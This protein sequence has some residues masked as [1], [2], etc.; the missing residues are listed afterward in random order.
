MSALILDTETTGKNDPILLIEAAWL[1]VEDVRTLSITDTFSQRYKPSKP[2]E[3]GAMAVHHIFDEEL[4]GC[5]ASDTF[6]LPDDVEYLVGHNIDYDWGVIGKPPVKRI[7]TLAIARK[8]WPDADSHSQSALLYRFATDRER[9]RNALKSAHSAESDV[10]FCRMILRKEVASIPQQP[11]SWEEL[12]EFSEQA[13]IPEVM[14]FGKHY[15]VPI[16][17][18]PKDYVRWALGNLSDM[19]EYLR[20]ALESVH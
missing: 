9:V 12:W 1:K 8:L 18:L 4:N 5:P 3:T 11:A 2:I 10:R 16:R 20:K 19:D 6:R 14:P 17:D 13:R 15:G 7:C